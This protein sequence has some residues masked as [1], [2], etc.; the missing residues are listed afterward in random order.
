MRSDGLDSRVV[1]AHVRRRG[2]PRGGDTRTLLRPGFR[3]LPHI[4]AAPRSLWFSFLLFLRP[5]L[6]PF[7]FSFDT[8]VA[9]VLGG[10]GG[11]AIGCFVVLV[12]PL[13]LSPA[14]IYLGRSTRASSLGSS[15]SLVLPSPAVHIVIRKFVHPSSIYTLKTHSSSISTTHTHTYVPCTTRQ[16]DAPIPLITAAT[17]LIRH[18]PT[19]PRTLIN[20]TVQLYFPFSYFCGR[21]F[22]FQSYFSKSTALGQSCDSFEE[23]H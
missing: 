9:L 2:P 8:L 4:T 20:L 10:V 16:T 23:T 7:I 12:V 6:G 21:G 22:T 1:D 11:G 19:L 15:S 5:S 18:P 13:R 3:R 17:A 14:S